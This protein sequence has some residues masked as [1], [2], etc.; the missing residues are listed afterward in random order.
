MRRSRRYF[1][2]AGERFPNLDW[3]CR[4]VRSGNERWKTSE[5]EEGQA[6]ASGISISVLF[7]T[8][9]GVSK[10]VAAWGGSD[11]GWT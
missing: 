11:L 1:G 8:D 10:Q 3:T 2:G 9:G 7:M 5:D 4:M 6:W